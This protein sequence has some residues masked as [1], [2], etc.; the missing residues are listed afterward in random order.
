MSNI[1][2]TNMKYLVNIDTYG[3]TELKCTIC[4]ALPG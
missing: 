2:L 1:I 3:C 4:G